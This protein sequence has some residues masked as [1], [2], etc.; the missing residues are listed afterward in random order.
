MIPH[1]TPHRYRTANLVC[2]PVLAEDGE[3]VAG[4]SQVEDG[5][6]PE[7]WQ[8]YVEPVDRRTWNK[9]KHDKTGLTA[10]QKLAKLAA[11]AGEVGVRGSG[12]VALGGLVAP[13]LRSLKGT[14]LDLDAGTGGWLASYESADSVLAASPRPFLLPALEAAAAAVPKASPRRPRRLGSCWVAHAPQALSEGPWCK[15]RR[16]CST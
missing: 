8:S 14:V 12:G 15:R 11:P 10:A 1:V 16:G 4:L 6:L 3:P 2:A 13:L 7:D 9:R 5:S